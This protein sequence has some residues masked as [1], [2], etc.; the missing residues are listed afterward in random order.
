M[1]WISL[2]LLK[3]IGTAAGPESNFQTSDMKH[4]AMTSGIELGTEPIS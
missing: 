1:T 3:L 4:N 2:S